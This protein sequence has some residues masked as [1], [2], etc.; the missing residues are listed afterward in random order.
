MRHNIAALLVMLLVLT[1]I[2][3][4]SSEIAA[5][6]FFIDKGACPFECCAYRKWKTEENTTAYARPDRSAAIIGTFKAGATVQGL[7]GEVH[8]QP[9]RF[10]VKKL[11]A[12]YRPGDV[13]WVYTYLGEGFFKVW[14]QGKMFEEE[15][16][17][18]PYGGSP[19]KRCEQLPRFCWGELEKELSFT[20]W[21]KVRSGDGWVGWSDRPDNFSNKDEC[22]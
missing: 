19:G 3:S 13:L 7:T 20:W 2:G 1:P 10:T 14:Y 18:S 12:G 17:F 9:A 16:G 15:L 4:F 5:P 22:G 6:Q 21:V 8:V 11:H